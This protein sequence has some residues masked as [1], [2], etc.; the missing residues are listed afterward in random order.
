M[1]DYAQMLHDGNGIPV[2]K[3][4]SAGHYKVAIDEGNISAM[5][6]YAVMLFKGDGVQMNK[7]EAACLS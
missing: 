2:N 7:K 3:A 1:N 6:S 5:A 4:E